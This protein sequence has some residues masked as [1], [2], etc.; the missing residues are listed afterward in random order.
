MTSRHD[1]DEMSRSYVSTLDV[2]R[3]VSI[4]NYLPLYAKLIEREI[5]S[6]DA[7]LWMILVD[8]HEKHRVG[9]AIITITSNIVCE[10]SGFFFEY[11]EKS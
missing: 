2:N 8:F 1:L 3:V 4:G 9:C 7:V 10:K 6:R 5:E 11:R